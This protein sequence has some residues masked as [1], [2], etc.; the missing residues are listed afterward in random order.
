[1]EKRP[2]R[3]IRFKHA[4]A[5]QLDDGSWEANVVL[6]WPES[7]DY[8]AKVG[9]PSS[10]SDS[11]TSSAQAAV[12]ALKQALGNDAEIGLL[13]AEEIQEI[14]AVVVVLSMADNDR[15]YRLTGSCAIDD[16]AP[17]AAVLAVLNATNRIVESIRTG[18]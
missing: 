2:S 17:R 16:M 7:E 18:V 13:A 15:V 1:V 6:A 5:R 8:S 9:E 14:N 10:L 3:R 12:D 4:D 11:V